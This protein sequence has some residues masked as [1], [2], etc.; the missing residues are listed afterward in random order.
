MIKN[1]V[2][3]TNVLIHDPNAI[4]SFEDNNLIIPLPVI[5]EIDKLKGRPGEIGM[6]ARQVAR[7]LDNLRKNGKLF[8]GVKIDGGGTLKVEVIED[9]KEMPRF[10]SDK[11]MD[12]W[13]LFYTM[14]IIRKTPDLKTILVSK[15]INMRIKA[16]ALGIEAQ[17][18]LKDKTDEMALFRGY[19]E[20]NSDPQNFDPVKNKVRENE[21]VK[22]DSKIFRFK[23][24]KFIPISV[25]Q[26][27]NVWGIH[28]LNFEQ[29]M[30]L[31]LLL[32]PD[33]N[34]VTL[35]GI[36]GTGK[37][38]L[39]IAAALEMVTNSKIYK[40]ITVTRPVIPMGKDIGF[41]PGSAE[42]KMKPW[43]EPIRDNLEFLFD[44]AGKS[45]S[46]IDS[47]NFLQVEALSYT[48]GR[49]IPH[50]FII[51]D[52]S[53]NLTP[54]EVKTIIT[55]AGIG[56]KIVL[57]GD[58]SQI[59]SPYLDAFSNGLSYVTAKFANQKIAGHLTLSI[60]VRSDLST[61]ASEI[62]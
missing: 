13:I 43:L 25:D 37:T 29:S 31:D 24:G 17:D 27:T 5:E 15:D 56:T 34:L 55:R 30:A 26:N 14:E 12:D 62:L 47:L 9:F 1:Y 18:Y 52:E 50:Q 11:V 22:F 4:H 40:K 36:A 33:L 28:P 59:D 35:M 19:L 8:K 16:D 7:E 53:Q 2:L 6:S 51:V 58:I 23:N 39:S 57:T 3:D 10:L 41:L 61:L 38:L 60:G 48:R 46:K 54:H 49:T 32:D 21:F 45:I 20:V 44:N 42:E